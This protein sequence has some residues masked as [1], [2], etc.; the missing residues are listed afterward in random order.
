[1][2][3]TEE[4]A[5]LGQSW[6]CKRLEASQAR[7]LDMAVAAEAYG[8]REIDGMAVGGILTVHQ[9]HGNG[10]TERQI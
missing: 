3:L 4:V 9:G 8:I 1:M 6:S 2:W 5:G 7:F 10:R